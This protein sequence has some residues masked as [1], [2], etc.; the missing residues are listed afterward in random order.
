[1]SRPNELAE[2]LEIAEVAGNWTTDGSLCAILFADRRSCVRKLERPVKIVLQGA[3][4]DVT[5]FASHADLSAIRD[6]ATAA[7]A[8]LEATRPEL[9]D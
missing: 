6:W 1:M 7:V 5:Y 3:A 8:A 2:P 9:V 4:F